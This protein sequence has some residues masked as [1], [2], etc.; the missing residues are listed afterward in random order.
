MFFLY[1]ATVSAQAAAAT[2]QPL[3]QTPNPQYPVQ[4]F[5][6]Q[7]APTAQGAAMSQV[8]TQVYCFTTS[9]VCVFT[10][11][12]LVFS[13]IRFIYN[14]MLLVFR[15]FCVINIYLLCCSHLFGAASVE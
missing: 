8:F 2:G 11:L 7:I 4:P 6:I 1:L 12:R 10:L 5:N 3:L 14:M 15:L 13:K 9:L